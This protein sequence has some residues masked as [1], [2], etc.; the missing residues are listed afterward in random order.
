MASAHLALLLSDQLEFSILGIIHFDINEHNR[1]RISFVFSLSIAD[2][3]RNG[4]NTHLIKIY[5][6]TRTSQRKNDAQY[7]YLTALVIK[8]IKDFFH[9]SPVCSLRSFFRFSLILK[10]M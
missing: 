7:K 4:D 1:Q 5:H 6:I 10:E 2:E 9:R 8:G 3:Y